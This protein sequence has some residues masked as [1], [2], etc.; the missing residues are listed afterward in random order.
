MSATPASLA[1]V[2]KC[3]STGRLVRERLGPNGPLA[4]IGALLERP[5]IVQR[6]DD[7]AAERFQEATEQLQQALL[8]ADTAAYLSTSGDFSAQTAFARGE[9]AS[10][11]NLD[12][13]KDAAREARD[14]LREIS[15]LVR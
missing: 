9:P 3:K 6:V 14:L 4:R 11:P 13:A 10:A 7:S 15:S 8:A 5:A 1:Q 12:R 2:V